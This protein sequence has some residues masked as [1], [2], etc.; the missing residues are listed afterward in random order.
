MRCKNCGY[1]SLDHLGHCRK[2]GGD[3]SGVRES[4]GFPALDPHQRNLVGSLL[5]QQ[6]A[7]EYVADGQSPLSRRE[8]DSPGDAGAGER[9][10][11]PELVLDAEKTPSFD[12]SKRK[13]VGLVIE[14][15]GDEELP[16]GDEKKPD[17]WK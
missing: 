4:L 1:V 5:K 11:S 15:D 10:G 12:I 17:G 6:A 16:E 7:A 3:L 13:G 8:I 2:C 9:T 14:I